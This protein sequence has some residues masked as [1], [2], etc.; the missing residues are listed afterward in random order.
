MAFSWSVKIDGT[1]VAPIVLAGAQIEYGRTDIQEQP[2]VP[3]AV[4][5][6]LTRDTSPYVVEDYPEFGLGDWASDLSGFTDDYKD[7]YEGVTSRITL[8][9]PVVI[10]AGSESGF[11]DEYVD[12]YAG[13]DFTRFTGRVQAIDYTPGT[14]QLTATPRS[15]E[16]SRIDV[17]GTI[18]DQNIPVEYESQRAKR[19]ALEAGI[20]LIVDG[21]DAVKVVAIPPETPPESLAGWLILLMNG[22]GGLVYTDRSGFVHVQTRGYVPPVVDPVTLPPGV[23]LLDPLRMTLELGLVRNR[24]TVEYGPLAD[25]SGGQ[26]RSDSWTYRTGTGAPGNTGWNRTDDG[27]PATGEPITIRISHYSSTNQAYEFSNVTTAM[28]FVIDGNSAGDRWKMDIDS[29]SHVPGP[30]G[31]S[32][33]GCTLTSV[34]GAI[35]N[36]EPCVIG[37][38][39]PDVKSRPTYTVE[40]PEQIARYGVRDYK[41]ATPIEQGADASIYA[42]TRLDQ[43]SPAWSMPDAVVAMQLLEDPDIARVCQIEQGWPIIL[44][45]LLLGSPVPSYES[46]VLGY[47]ENLSQT[48]WQ[49]ALHLAPQSIGAP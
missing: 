1:N 3:V 38:Y 46:I 17:G 32:T 26:V 8:G 37:T 14:I 24:V 33:F 12:A 25:A 47:T 49:I 23:T 29:I 10:S 34:N 42:Q 35:N 45:Q 31:Y 22:T 6:L 43:L 28:R 30:N 19:L 5:E 13:T 15:E 20:A 18:V 16:W 21:P 39:S 41:T 40:D 48:D 2:N 9:V 44:P 27:S 11:T 36:N 4:L 7:P